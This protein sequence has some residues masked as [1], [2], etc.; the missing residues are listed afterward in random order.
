[1][2]ESIRKTDTP[3]FYVIN[4]LEQLMFME[5]ILQQNDLENCT[6]CHFNQLLAI[7]HAVYSASAAA[8]NKNIRKLAQILGDILH[9]MQDNRPAYPSCRKL[10]ELLFRCISHISVEL[11]YIQCNIKF[12]SYASDFIE[13]AESMLNSIGE[14]EAK[15][16][17]I[18]TVMRNLSDASHKELC[19]SV[20]KAVIFFDKNH[21]LEN[22]RAFSVI[23]SIKK[24]VSVINY[25]PHDIAE[26]YETADEIRKNGFEINF[27]SCLSFKELEQI[28]NSSFSVRL[29]KLEKMLL[30]QPYEG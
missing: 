8:D 26:R 19:E 27:S 1:M 20:Y 9:Y 5:D 21:K 17:R 3:D 30:C 24:S 25:F 2:H 16:Y 28:L 10:S 23:N 11:Y 4:T 22:I 15:E 18:K 6:D 12:Y 7:T 13:E 29:V 14:K